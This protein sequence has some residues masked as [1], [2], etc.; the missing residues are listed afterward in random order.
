MI[1][2]EG[3]YLD[4]GMIENNGSIIYVICYIDYIV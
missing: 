2:R 1:L 4:F 3:I